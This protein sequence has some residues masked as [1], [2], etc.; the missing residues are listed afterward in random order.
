[1][2]SHWRKGPY[3]PRQAK[4]SK[5]PTAYNRKTGTIVGLDELKPLFFAAANSSS[6][7]KALRALREEFDLAC[8]N[9]KRA[10]LVFSFGSENP[11]GTIDRISGTNLPGNP[12]H[13][14]TKSTKE[15]QVHAKGCTGVVIDREPNQ[16]DPNKG[17]LLY[18]NLK[19]IPEEHP[20]NRRLIMREPGGKIVRLDPDLKGRATHKISKPE[21]VLALMRSGQKERLRN[22]VAV[23][24]DRKIPWIEFM[25]PSN[26]TRDP[27]PR[28]AEFARTFFREGVGHPIIIDLKFVKATASNYCDDDGRNPA[29]HYKFP[30]T[31][32]IDIPGLGEIVIQPELRVPNRHLVPT[33]EAL[34]RQQG[35]AF[36]I[37]SRPFLYKRDNVTNIYIMPIVLT[38]PDMIVESSLDDIMATAKKRHDAAHREQDLPTP[39]HP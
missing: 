16:I 15:K 27:N 4:V 21:D 8:P 37:T 30:K 2:G 25:I 32:P 26:D 9:C 28:M 6:P 33:T 17:F 7:K 29:K 11:D 13:I 14:K 23:F 24:G 18:L 19:N 3:S 10:S 34:H 31:A 1:M 22:S 38:D 36:V 39:A 5:F 20:I 12:A 35:E